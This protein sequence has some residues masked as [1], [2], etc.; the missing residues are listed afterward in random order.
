MGYKEREAKILELL[1][2]DGSLTYLQLKESLDVSEATVRRDLERMD[3]EKLLVRYWGGAKRS[4]ERAVRTRSILDGI[5][6]DELRW[7]GEVAGGKVK[8]NELIFIGSG[9]STLTMIDY[10]EETDHLTVITNG[11]PQLEACN[12]KG[13]KAFLLCGFLKEYS[14]AVVGKQTVEMLK[15]YHFDKAFLG[16]NGI[17]DDICFLSGDEYE[18]D[19]KNISIANSKESY[20]LAAHNKF[21]RTAMYSLSYKQCRNTTIISDKPMFKAEGWKKEN[22]AYSLKV[23]E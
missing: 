9:L 4:P 12:R 15:G 8:G 7:I 13:I 11:I 20:V 3:K 2:L 6:S 16:V 19:I 14:R 1:D 5:I 21:H 18:Y 22:R 17:S 10:I 23:A